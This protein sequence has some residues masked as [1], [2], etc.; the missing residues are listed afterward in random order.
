MWLSRLVP[1]TLEI[2]GVEGGE[3]ASSWA[4]AGKM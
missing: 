1:S 2:H 4:S 3:I